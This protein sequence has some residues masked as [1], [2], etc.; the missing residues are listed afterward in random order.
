MREVL[1]RWRYVVACAVV[2]SVVTADARGAA[3]VRKADAG[4]RARIAAAKREIREPTLPRIIR[5]I[6]KSLS[7]ELTGPRP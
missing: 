7:D 2:L 5:R 4:A 1:V 3:P 6:V